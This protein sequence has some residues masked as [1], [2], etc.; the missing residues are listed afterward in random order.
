MGN[1]TL[2]V[3]L[4]NQMVSK[5][6][7][8]PECVP[9]YVLSA[10][11]SATETEKAQFVD[12]MNKWNSGTMKK[13]HSMEEMMTLIQTEA[14]GIY[15]KSQQLMNEYKTRFEKLSPEAKAFMKKVR[16]MQVLL[17]C[18]FVVGAAASPTMD[19]FT[20]TV[21]SLNKA[22]EKVKQHPGEN[23]FG[24]GLRAFYTLTQGKNTK[25]LTKISEE[26]MEGN[27]TVGEVDQLIFNKKVKRARSAIHERCPRNTLL[28][29]TRRL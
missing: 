22:I 19:G 10:I 12:F 21:D 28:Q 16:D 18:L 29:M 15:Q 11:T 4:L 14:P 8:H 24:K 23:F 9:N 6:K 2:T 17:L 26:P 1:F 27:G 25:F 13:P 5:I 3:D 20:L 7:E